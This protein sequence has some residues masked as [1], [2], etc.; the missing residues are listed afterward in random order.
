MHARELCINHGQYYSNDHKNRD[1]ILL[2]FTITIIHHAGYQFL[3]VC[4][5]AVAARLLLHG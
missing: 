4:A 2:Y 5:I 1:E 3:C